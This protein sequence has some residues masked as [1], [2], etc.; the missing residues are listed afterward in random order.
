[1]IQHKDITDA[2]VIGKK[3]ENDVEL[4]KAFIVRRSGSQITEADVQAH[5]K[6]RL[7]R[8]KQL[9]GGVQ[10]VD[11]IPKLPS[12]KILK[13]ILREAEKEGRSLKL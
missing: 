11:N 8:Y 13:R 9:Q 4:P 1:M 5:M 2:A 3:F 12:G 6:E 10:F 7:A